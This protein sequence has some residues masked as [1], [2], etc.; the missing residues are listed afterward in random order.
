[1]DFKLICDKEGYVKSAEAKLSVPEALLV[2]IAL[3][4]LL[5][6]DYTHE[7][8]KKTLVKMLSDMRKG[9]TNVQSKED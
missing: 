8:D 9:E 4:S 1:M 6:N 2:S 7:D 3:S 5:Y